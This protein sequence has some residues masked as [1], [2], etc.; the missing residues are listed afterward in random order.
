[1]V[2]ACPP[3]ETGVSWIKYGAAATLCV[4]IFIAWGNLNEVQSEHGMNYTQC[5]TYVQRMQAMPE[6][7]AETASV[8]SYEDCLRV[9]A[10]WPLVRSLVDVSKM[11]ERGIEFLVLGL[12]SWIGGIAVGF[13]SALFGTF[14]S[15]ALFL[16][17]ATIVFV[18][19]FVRSA[20]K[21]FEDKDRSMSSLG[22]FAASKPNNKPPF[23]TQLFQLLD[24]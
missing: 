4:A 20:L 13:F 17:V 12:S 7:Q 10:Q 23:S 19:M 11:C 3:C 14:Q 2:R 21:R 5:S 9:T 1:M 16:T 22:G 24:H 15:I 6:F 18:Y 8:N